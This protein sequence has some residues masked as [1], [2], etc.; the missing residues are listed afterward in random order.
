M[1]T[2]Q[3]LHDRATRLMPGGVNSPVRAFGAVGGTP[4]AIAGGAGATIADVEG[5]TYTDYVS[6]WG[7]LILGHAHPAV[8]AAVHEAVDAGLSFGAPTDRE[9][10]LA[11]RVVA[12]A[13][14]V[15]MVRMV[16]SGTEAT[17]SALRLARGATGTASSSWWTGTGST[18]RSSAGTCGWKGR[19]RR[20]GRR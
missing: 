8:V 16:N 7:P 15:E 1:S 13:P 6:S 12:D 4:R 18:S 9:V 2:N 17:M 3:D 19:P 5:R 10:A 11:E 14:S 20:P